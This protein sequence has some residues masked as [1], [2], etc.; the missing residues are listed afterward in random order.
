LRFCIWFFFFLTNFIHQF[1][2]KSFRTE[3]ELTL[4]DFNIKFAILSNMISKIVIHN[5]CLLIV[6]VFWRTFYEQLGDG[7]VLCYCKTK[8]QIIIFKKSEKRGTLIL[9]LFFPEPHDRSI[10]RAPNADKKIIN[11]LK[12]ALLPF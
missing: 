12:I 8:L 3:P 10:C 5:N 6:F 1:N 2:C 11:Q 9:V 7:D 4:V